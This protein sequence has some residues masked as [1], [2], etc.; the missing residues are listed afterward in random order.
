MINEWYR[1]AIPYT[2][3]AGSNL[4][5]FACLAF[6]CLRRHTTQAGKEPVALAGPPAIPPANGAD[7][8]SFLT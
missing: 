4:K 2:T 7:L 3:R 8:R 6:N 1:T 5:Y